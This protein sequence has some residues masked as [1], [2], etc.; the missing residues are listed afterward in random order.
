MKRARDS[1]CFG[2]KWIWHAK[3]IGHMIGTLFLRSYE[4]GERIY[5]AMVSRGYDGEFNRIRS[6][7]LK[8]GDFVFVS[9]IVLILFSVRILAA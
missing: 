1:R 6:S 3:T 7:K 4:R 8:A 5:I 2:G 9:S